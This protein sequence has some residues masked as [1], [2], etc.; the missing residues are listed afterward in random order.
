MR[1]KTK[2]VIARAKKRQAEQELHE[3]WEKPNH[4][5]K[6]VKVT[7]KDGKDIEGGRCMRGRDGRLGFHWGKFGRS[8]W[9]KF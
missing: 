3:L 6:F 5:F 2:K 9:R 4:I 8:T 1:N 7:K